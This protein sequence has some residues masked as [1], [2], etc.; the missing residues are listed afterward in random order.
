[1]QLGVIDDFQ[2]ER[3]NEMGGKKIVDSL[4]HGVCGEIFIPG[5]K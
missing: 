3:L 1:M 2:V 4:K 5:D